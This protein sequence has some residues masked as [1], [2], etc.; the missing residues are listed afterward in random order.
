M[1]FNKNKR[2]K[3]NTKVLFKVIS[4]Q[5]TQAKKQSAKQ[6]EIKP[7]V[8][9]IVIGQNNKEQTEVYFLYDRRQNQLFEVFVVREEIFKL[10]CYFF[11]R[12]CVCVGQQDVEEEDAVYYEDEEE[13]QRLE[14]GVSFE[15][16]RYSFVPEN[17]QS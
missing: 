17:E 11:Q 3:E 5:V 8:E 9:L 2:N 12:V 14:L 7:V 6:A 13:L 10:G 1:N 15:G 4:A 16:R